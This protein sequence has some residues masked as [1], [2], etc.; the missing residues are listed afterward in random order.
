MRYLEV[1]AVST[2]L[3]V[4]TG[5][6]GLLGSHLAEQLRQRGERVRALVRPSSDTS[7]LKSIGV[8]LVEGDLADMA[9]LRRAFSGADIVYHAAAKVGDWGRWGEFQTHI[10]DATANVVAAC[11]QEPVGRLLHVSSIIVYG[12]P[13]PRPDRIFNEDMPLGQH[14]WL[15]DYYCRAKIGAER[16]IRSYPGA[17]T[18]VRPSWIYGP[19][20]RHSL[21][22]MIKALRAGRVHLIGDGENMLNLV[23]AGDVADGCIRAALAPHAVGQTYNLASSGELTQRKLLNAM[24]DALGYPRIRSRIPFGFAFWIGFASEI[25]ATVIRLRRPPHI[26]RHIVGLVARPTIHSTSKA[27]GQLSW[28]PQVTIQEGLKRTLDWYWNTVE[29]SRKR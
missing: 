11:R 5:A 10:I 21:P 24:T 1:C 7:F 14:L 4:V 6:T 13:Q 18:I 9:S 20:D 15:W 26:T 16:A 29:T 2:R 25:I 12:H 23:Y 22:R 8:E 28:Q 17:W 27:R 19:R 3:N